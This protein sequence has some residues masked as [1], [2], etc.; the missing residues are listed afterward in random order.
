MKIKFL[1]LMLGLG[2]FLLTFSCKKVDK[3]RAIVKVVETIDSV[4][5]P[6][7]RA[8]VT[9][10]PATNEYVLD[11]VVAE[12]YTNSSGTI[13]FEFDK[14]LVLRAIGNKVKRDDQGNVVLDNNGKPIILKTGYRTL[15]LKQEFT[16]NKVIEVR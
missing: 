11:D 6:V 10:G 1:F 8:Y 4:L 7:S 5:V 12:G 14:E 3:P 16:D 9:V 2:V 13:E 15:V